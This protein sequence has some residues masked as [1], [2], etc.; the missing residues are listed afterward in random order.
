[1][2]AICL[3]ERILSRWIGCVLL[4]KLDTFMGLNFRRDGLSRFL[5]TSRMIFASIFFL[6]SLK[7][8]SKAL[9][10]T[11]LMTRGIPLACSMITE[12]ALGVNVSEVLLPTSL[13][14]CSI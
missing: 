14:R 2:T 7:P 6:D 4:T 10:H 3:G 1:M 11:M 5:M 9:S 13:R 12:I 8:F